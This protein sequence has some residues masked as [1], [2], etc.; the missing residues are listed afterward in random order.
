MNIAKDFEIW[1]FCNI[2]I[3]ENTLKGQKFVTQQKCT[4][5]TWKS[6]YLKWFWPVTEGI[7]LLTKKKIKHSIEDLIFK[8]SKIK[9]SLTNY[10]SG[11]KKKI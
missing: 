5:K 6:K 1:Q 10:K 9:K 7:T 2:E 8:P 4:L 3:C 11:K